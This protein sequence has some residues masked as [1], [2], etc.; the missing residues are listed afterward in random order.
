MQNNLST[1]RNRVYDVSPLALG[2]AEN[3]YVTE[4][5]FVFGTVQP[6]FAQV[7]EPQMTVR[8]NNRIS[9]PVGVVNQ[10]EVGGLY[11]RRMD[12]GCRPLGN[13]SLSAAAG[14][15]TENRVLIRDKSR[16]T[17]ITLRCGD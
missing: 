14:N 15:I 1:T 8:V 16:L 5:M 3:E 12:T 9:S 4:V 11:Q 10:A 6:G 7:E 2:L 13:Q 17:G